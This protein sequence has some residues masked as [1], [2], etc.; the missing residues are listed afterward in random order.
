MERINKNHLN[1]SQK[2]NGKS[3]K[4][5]SDFTERREMVKNQI[6]SFYLS[7]RREMPVGNMLDIEVNLALSDWEEIPSDH[8]LE[9]CTLARKSSGSFLASNGSVVAIWREIKAELRR[10]K[11][12]VFVPLPAPER[13]EEE[14]EATAKYLRD[15]AESYRKGI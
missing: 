12:E 13:T 15:L 4:P 11:N 7:A 8:L 10:P 9:V 5:I 6:I 2:E 14:K 3:S 1:Q